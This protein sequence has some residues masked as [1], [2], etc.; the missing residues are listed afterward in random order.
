MEFNLGPQ[1]DCTCDV[2][3]IFIACLRMNSYSIN[4]SSLFT[5]PSFQHALEFL[6]DRVCAAQRGKEFLYKRDSQGKL[7]T[8]QSRLADPN[9]GTAIKSFRKAEDQ[10]SKLPHKLW[11]KKELKPL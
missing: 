11:G 6:V 10:K 5:K 9:H 2:Y 7:V 4:H 8:R 1:V 3:L